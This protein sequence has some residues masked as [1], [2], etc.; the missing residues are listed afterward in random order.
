MDEYDAA[1]ANQ[2]FLAFIIAR[3]VARGALTALDVSDAIESERRIIESL[4]REGPDPRLLANASDALAELLADSF[5]GH[6]LSALPFSRW[7]LDPADPCWP[8][9]PDNDP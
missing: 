3:L 8:A 9:L 2:H 4:R 5:R 6:G 7:S 1:T